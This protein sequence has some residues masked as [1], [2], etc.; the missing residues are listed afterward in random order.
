MKKIHL[1]IFRLAIKIRRQRERTI[2]IMNSR[3]VRGQ[4]AS[5]DTE[6]IVRRLEANS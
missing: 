6:N 2:K 3:H 1:K 5:P 4:T